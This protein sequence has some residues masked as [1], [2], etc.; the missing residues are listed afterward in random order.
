MSK[1][2]EL[3]WAMHK[4]AEAQPFARLLIS[5][6]IT[7]QLYLEYL[8]NQRLIYSYLEASAA[9]WLAETL[10]GVFRSE[11]ILFDIVQLEMMHQLSVQPHAIKPST[12]EYINYVYKVSQM[13]LDQQRA[14]LLPHL[15]VRHFGDMYGGAMIQKRIPGSG[16]MYDFDDKEF[17]IEALRGELNDGMADEANICFQYA[18]RLFQEL[19]PKDS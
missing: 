6:K 12:S 7:P 14:K 11:K 16:T 15:Y 2:K 9:N 1:L 5:G 13:P 19:A 4:S 18:T 17:L 3:T 8:H 10:H